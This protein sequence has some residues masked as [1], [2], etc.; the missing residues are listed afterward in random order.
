MT[1]GYETLSDTCQFAGV[2]E[3]RLLTQLGAMVR[4]E[5]E[6]HDLTQQALANLAGTSQAAIARIERG[7]RA[8]SVPMLER[9]FAALGMQ[10]TIGVEPLDAHV[11]AAIGEQTQTTLADRIAEASLAKVAAALADIPHVFA[12]PAAALIQ[13]APVPV[14]AVD[15]AVEWRHADAFTNWLDLRY[16]RR[17]HEKWQE[18]GYLAIDPR[19]PGAHRWQ[20]LF[21]EIRARMCDELPESI[22]VRHGEQSYRV[23][24]LAD[25]ELD[26]PR[27]ANLLRRYRQLR[28]A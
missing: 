14:D 17:W 5:R 20:T 13:G 12:G 22:E 28:S 18:F 19:L 24:P 16:A 9:L 11:D 15:I 8:P 25:V 1:Q 3:S 26:D 7:D 6:R 4:R 23:V 10:L 27:A 21:G 2:T